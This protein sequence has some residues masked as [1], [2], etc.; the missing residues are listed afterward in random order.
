MSTVLALIELLTKRLLTLSSFLGVIYFF[1]IVTPFDVPY[2]SLPPSFQANWEGYVAK[3][4][5]LTVIFV[6]FSWV[7]LKIASSV[8]KSGDTLDVRE[9]K[10]I[11]STAMPTYIG[12]FVIA[13]GLKDDKIA[14]SFVVLA[15]LLILWGYFERVFYFNPIWILF[16]FRFY[17]AKTAQENTFTLITKRQDLKQS[18]QFNGLRRINEYTFLEV[19]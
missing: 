11:E 15:V 2:A 4:V 3:I 12:L 17:E 14:Q 10:P 5:F 1:L 8:F 19:K 13:L 7:T 6:I 18:Q 16:G 9:I